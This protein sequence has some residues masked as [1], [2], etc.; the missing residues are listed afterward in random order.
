M[1]LNCKMHKDPINV[2]KSDYQAAVRNY[3]ELSDVLDLELLL[4]KTDTSNFSK[5]EL[6]DKIQD[7]KKHFEKFLVC[8]KKLILILGYAFEKFL[9]RKEDVCEEIKNLLSE[10]I[11]SNLISRRVIERYCL[12]GWKKRTKP[13]KPREND[14]LS[15]SK[16]TPK[17]APII[18]Q[19]KGENISVEVKE[20][21]FSDR[22]QYDSPQEDER[23]SKLR[24]SCGSGNHVHSCTKCEIKDSRIA[25][26]CAEI[27]GMTAQ[28]TNLRK[29]I[30]TLTDRLKTKETSAASNG[31]I[32]TFSYPIIFEDLRFQ[33][34]QIFRKTN[35]KGNVWLNGR[36]DINT[37][38]IVELSVDTA[39]TKA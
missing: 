7:V 10:E 29:Q 36:L 3:V 12:A 18:N 33:M 27:A 38:K 11:A 35:G 5:A 32:F 16:T 21:S 25:D 14:N 20:S 2:K 37:M 30:T 22:D 8:R 26:L 34:E 31:E 24:S 39:Q 15:F 6:E 19:A 28:T 1:E 4:L 13:N 9:S 17:V 23:K